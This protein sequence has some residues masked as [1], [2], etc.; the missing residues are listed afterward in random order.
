M[1]ANDIVSMRA[2]LGGDYVGGPVGVPNGLPGNGVIHRWWRGP[3]GSSDD[4]RRT[5]AIAIELTARST[6]KEKIP[7]GSTNCTAT[8]Q[9]TRPDNAQTTDWYS[10]FSALGVGDLTAAQIDLSQTTGGNQDWMCYRYKLYQTVVP[11]RNL[12]WTPG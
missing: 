9:Q 1:I 7:Q 12:S 3:I 11:L 5:I 10:G 8:R 2:L 6:V 4:V